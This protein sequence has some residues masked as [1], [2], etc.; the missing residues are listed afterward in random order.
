MHDALLATLPEPLAATPPVIDQAAG[1]RRLFAGTGV[2]FVP[3]VSNPH[4]AFGG[5]MIERLCAA[6]AERGKH[7][8]VIDAAERSPAASDLALLDLAACV[9]PLSDSV[10]YLAARGLPIRH[11]DARG[12][13]RGFLSA[14]ADAAPAAQ[15]LLVHANASDLARMFS[16]RGEPATTRPILLADDR[17]ASVTHA[18]AAIKQLHQRAGVVVFDLLLGAADHSPRAE[19]I[20]AQ[21]AGCADQF[22]GAVVRDWARLDPACEPTDPV[23]AAL[24][25]LAREA[26]RG[27]EHVPHPTANVTT[28][29]RARSF[30]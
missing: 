17:P 6:F 26:L 1:L 4:V 21:L 12:S 20:A 23:D 9:E 5:V 24:R 3:L 16:T 10:S 8:L 29:A 14:A 11:V 25:R 2:Q 18:Y 30:L 15:V 28:P 27:G 13:T 22:L 7:T 19:R